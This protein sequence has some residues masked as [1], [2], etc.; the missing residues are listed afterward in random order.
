MIFCRPSRHMPGYCLKVGRERFLP[1]YFN[2]SLFIN[3]IKASGYYMYR[4]LQ[5]TKTSHSAQAVHSSLVCFLLFTQ[6][7]EEVS[8]NR[9]NQFIFV[10]GLCHHVGYQHEEHTVSI[11]CVEWNS[12]LKMRAVFSSK[13]LQIL[14]LQGYTVS[15]LKRQHYMILLRVDNL[16]LLNLYFNGFDQRV[17][18]QQLC[19]HGS[20]R[21][22]RWGCFLCRPRHAQRY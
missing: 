21:N 18:R 11:F 3:P 16:V 2:N 17:A 20:T 9:I 22:N 19:K 7:T 1:H 6:Q 10:S 5:H 12:T 8:K 4:L 15:W 14:N 13:T